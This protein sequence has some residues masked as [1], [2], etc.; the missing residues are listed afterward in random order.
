MPDRQQ[1]NVV[2]L[3]A[4]YYQRLNEA[5]QSILGYKV[6]EPLMSIVSYQ[7]IPTRQVVIS[8]SILDEYGVGKSYEEAWL[9]LFHSLIGWRESMEKR[10][11]RLSEQTLAEYSKLCALLV[12]EE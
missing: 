10:V 1:V 9:D 8:C 5:G 3:P 2:E 11:H 12:R 4:F 6:S 7:S